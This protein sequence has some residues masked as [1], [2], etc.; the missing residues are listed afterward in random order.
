[1]RSSA[2]F[3]S[4]LITG[5]ML[6]ACDDGSGP[7]NGRLVINLTDA[8]GDLAEAFVSIR[9]VILIGAEG[10]ESAEGRIVLTPQT[11]EYIDLLT[12]TGGNVLELVDAS[13][14]TGTYSELR[15]V[16]DDA[17]VQ[18]L[19][20]RVFA[21]AGA[22]LPAGITSSGTLRCPSCSSSGFK[23]KFVDGGLDVEENAVVLI[24]FDVA[25]SF[26]H[27]AGQSGAWVMHPVLRATATTVRLGTIKGNVTLGT[28]VALPACGE[29]AGTLA[30]FRPTATLGSDTFT[31]AADAQGAYR[32]E[33]LMPGAYTLGSIA[34]IS[35]TNGD[36]LTIT[37][38]PAATGVNLAAG[39]SI[40][41]DYQITAAI[42]H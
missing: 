42:C 22:A 38:A 14:P 31:G 37:A 27:D 33:H 29:Q 25:Q 19:D 11:T 7:E 2:K 40:T 12:L 15:L 8:P 32:I 18:L 39:D 20:G 16:F 17:Y 35:F 34:D 26:G 6:G 21:T 1:M 5:L 28:G 24:D 23:V 41:A 36:T 4:I 30:L 3:L 13:V 10:D 9:E